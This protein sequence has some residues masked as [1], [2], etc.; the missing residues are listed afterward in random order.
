MVWGFEALVLV[1]DGKPPPNHQTTGLQT[2]NRREADFVSS[3]SHKKS[4]VP[5]FGFEDHF[6]GKHKVRLLV[7]GQST[8]EARK[9]GLE[10]F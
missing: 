9:E 6:S 4:P 2:T 1:V 7:V 3:V 10:P 8:Q 5:F